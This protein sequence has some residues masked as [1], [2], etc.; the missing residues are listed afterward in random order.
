MSDIERPRLAARQQYERPHILVVTDD[1]DL[2][3]FLEEGLPLGG[4][5]MSLIASGIQA[6]EVFRL[7]QFDLVLIDLELGSFRSLELIRRLRGLSDRATGEAPRTTAPIVTIATEE[8]LDAADRD[9]LGI[10]DA[11][12]APLNIEEVVQRLHEVFTAWRQANPDVPL[13]DASAAARA[14]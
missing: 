14:R 6:L 3:A 7:R 5:W 12:K 13:A 11:M 1:P 10:A 9:T 4:F 8:S 2:A